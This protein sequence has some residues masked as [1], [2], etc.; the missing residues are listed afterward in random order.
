M[1]RL[2]QGSGEERARVRREIRERL[3]RREAAERGERDVW[4]DEIPSKLSENGG[5]GK[6]RPRTGVSMEPEAPPTGAS[7]RERRAFGLC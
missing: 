2:V 4:P 5:G 6:R 3:A 7:V 1:S